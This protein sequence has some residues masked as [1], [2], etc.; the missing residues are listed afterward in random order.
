MIV[1][2]L[3]QALSP[4]SGSNANQMYISNRLGLRQKAKE[5]GHHAIT[6]FDDIG[7]VAELVREHRMMETQGAIAAPEV[8][9]L[10]NNLVIVGFGTLLDFHKRLS[11]RSKR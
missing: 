4:V 7:R 10:G 3:R 9:D 8:H 6:V 2:A 11:S 1:E 5:I